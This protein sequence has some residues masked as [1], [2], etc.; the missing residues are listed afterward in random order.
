MSSF[1]FIMSACSKMCYFLKLF[2]LLPNHFIHLSG[3]FELLSYPFPFLITPLVGT[4]LST[5]Y[6]YFC[7][8]FVCVPL[9]LIR[10]PCLSLSKRLF[11]GTSTSYTG[12]TTKK[13]K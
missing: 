3:E 1:F 12:Y 4:L 13:K 6:S 5:L 8:F 2:V 10:T 7:A 11:T 9:N